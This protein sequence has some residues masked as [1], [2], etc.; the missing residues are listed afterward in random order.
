[1]CA[2]A[3]AASRVC[4][5]SRVFDNIIVYS[6]GGGVVRVEQG[7]RAVE[8][9]LVLLVLSVQHIVD[10]KRVRVRGAAESLGAL[11]HVRL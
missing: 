4:P 10:L 11:A 2:R 5:A 7:K 3:R 9:V 8:W 1:M 6:V